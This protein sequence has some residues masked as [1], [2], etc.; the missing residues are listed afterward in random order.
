MEPIG[1]LQAGLVSSIAEI[2]QG[3]LSR[4][5]LYNSARPKLIYIII[6]TVWF[7][8][9]GPYYMANIIRVIRSYNVWYIGYVKIILSDIHGIIIIMSWKLR[10]F[11]STD[12]RLSPDRSNPGNTCYQFFNFKSSFCPAIKCILLTICIWTFFTFNWNIKI[13]FINWQITSCGR[14]DLDAV[15]I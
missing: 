15:S 14:V 11:P 9:Y 3:S 12:S 2:V 1:G 7:I 13:I 5:I 4:I 8:Q 10:G 6:Y